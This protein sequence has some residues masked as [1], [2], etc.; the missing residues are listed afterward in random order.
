MKQDEM[1]AKQTR[2]DDVVTYINNIYKT[3]LCPEQANL[4]ARASDELKNIAIAS[5][6]GDEVKRVMAQCGKIMSYRLESNDER[7]QAE[8]VAAQVQ[9][10]KNLTEIIK[11]H[12]YLADEMMHMV[13]SEFQRRNERHYPP[14]A[15]AEQREFAQMFAA[16]AHVRQD[17][18]LWTMNLL[19]TMVKNNGIEAMESI[20]SA[21][22]DIL[23]EHKKGRLIETAPQE[24][25]VEMFDF[26]VAHAEKDADVA[27]AI[28]SAMQRATDIEP[29]LALDGCKLAV[30]VLEHV[31][32]DNVKSSAAY[33]I[34]GAMVKEKPE[35][36]QFAVVAIDKA[37][38]AVH[39][40]A[41]AD[42][43]YGVLLAAVQQQSALSE[44]VLSSLQKAPLQTP[45]TNELLRY[46][47]TERPDLAR[48]AL[49]SA[50]KPDYLLLDTF[51]H[52]DYHHHHRVSAEGQQAIAQ[53][54]PFLTTT[55]N[56]VN[57]EYVG[58]SE[59]YERSKTLGKDIPE[60]IP[61]L[62][63]V[64]VKSYNKFHTE[65]NAMHS[66]IYDQS[67][68]FMQ[69]AS[70][71][72]GDANTANAI[73]KE[74]F[75][76]LDKLE[77]GDQKRL[78]ILRQEFLPAQ[79]IE[80]TASVNIYPHTTE[81]VAENDDV[82]VVETAE[83]PLFTTTSSDEDYGG[84]TDDDLADDED[85]DVRVAADED[86]DDLADDEDDENQEVTTITNDS[87]F[88]AKDTA[89]IPAETPL[90]TTTSSDEDDDDLADDDLA[91]DEFDENDV[92]SVIS[93]LEGVKDVL[94]TSTQT[95]EP[96]APHVRQL[97]DRAP[98]PHAPHVR[99]LKDRAPEPH[100]SHK[101]TFNAEKEAAH[102]AQNTLARLRRRAAREIDNRLGTSL[103][104]VELA[105]RLKQAEEWAVGMFKRRNR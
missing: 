64:Y 61:E 50:K 36:A 14:L 56:D 54:E 13:E 44:K 91:D 62:V 76:T 46:V 87:D 16:V 58:F 82:R 63:E 29:K 3:P 33:N 1:T 43:A 31:G 96:H 80:N 93:G 84:L 19:N 72:V 70:A 95:P 98:E 6:N 35:F 88:V 25:M 47:I 38:P 66:E 101:R 53:M 24:K 45:K 11:M 78:E 77:D 10:I 17:M 52:A 75:A 18:G 92:R 104:N 30:K 83:T 57:G 21:A 28:S 69:Y 99:Q 34:I 73:V 59:N 100:A 42:S 4:L 41:V 103:E 7:G 81:N 23:Q 71:H 8:V 22:V 5:F 94:H 2:L 65:N 105:P 15:V 20:A 49:R 102:K 67:H 9:N 40:S 55:Y 85:D 37:L 97:K 89:A 26:A 60:Y 79:D 51:V 68:E 12:P 39:H 86:Y 74:V 48:Q 90:Y 27:D 32:A